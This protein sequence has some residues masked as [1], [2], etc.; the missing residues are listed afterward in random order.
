MW[1]KQLFGHEKPVIGM[2]HLDCLPGAAA[3]DCTAG[4][5]R[6]IDHAK[7]DYENLVLG[8]IDGVI[9]CNEC[10]KPYEKEIGKESVAAMTAVVMAVLA[11]NRAVP[12][13]IDMQWDPMASLAVANATGSLFIRGILCGSFCGDLGF[14]TPDT[15]AIAKYRRRIGAVHIKTITNLMPE[16]SRSIDPRP[17]SL[18]AQTVSKSALVDAICVS[19]TMAGQ[20]A[21]LEQLSEIKSVSELPVFANTGV[22]FETISGIMEIVDGCVVA[23]CLK[24]NGLSGERVE[25]E[26]VRRLMSL[27]VGHD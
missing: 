24:T 16:F 2:V 20:A 13:G 17:I 6:V 7:S 23:T 5:S 1:V 26:R 19:G 8:G 4:L 14:L 18:I 12:C 25:A 3:Y 9:F 21:A 11:G 15:A 22:N 10:D 27:S